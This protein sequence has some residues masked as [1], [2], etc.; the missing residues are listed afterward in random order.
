MS[1][2][3]VTPLNI[4][5]VADA[6]E[7]VGEEAVTYDV[8]A[9]QKQ[10][11]ALELKVNE[12]LYNHNETTHYLQEHRKAFDVLIAQRWYRFIWWIWPFPLPAYSRKTIMPLIVRD[13]VPK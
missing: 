3:R 4:P 1:R 13:V 7:E 12:L 10:V 2:T 5:T 11:R 8:A 9:L 6:I